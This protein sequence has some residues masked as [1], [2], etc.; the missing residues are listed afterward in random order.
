MMRNFH[1]QMY[2]FCFKTTSLTTG[3]AM[4]DVKTP[5]ANFFFD[6]D[7]FYS[8]YNLIKPFYSCLTQKENRLECLSPAFFF[9]FFRASPNPLQARVGSN[10]TNSVQYAEM[11]HLG[12]LRPYSQ[13]LVLPEKS[14]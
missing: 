7:T 5:S 4:T 8:A 9:H 2:R 11:V 3:N 1:G 10:L 13:V 12:R 14:Q 6:S